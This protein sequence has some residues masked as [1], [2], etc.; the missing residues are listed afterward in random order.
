M[1]PLRPCALLVML[2]RSINRNMEA[3]T[4]TL[5]RTQPVTDPEG[6]APPPSDPEPDESK[7][8]ADAEEEEMAELWAADR[9]NQG[10]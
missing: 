7:A 1:L 9:G 5:E 8:F 3:D 10:A 4:M 2:Q 6:T